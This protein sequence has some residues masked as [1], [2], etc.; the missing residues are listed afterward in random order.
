MDASGVNPIDRSFKVLVAVAVDVLSSHDLVRQYSL[1]SLKFITTLPPCHGVVSGSSLRVVVSV[2]C[3]K[4]KFVIIYLFTLLTT[5]TGPSTCDT[6]QTRNYFLHSINYSLTNH[7][8]LC[9]LARD[10]KR[11]QIHEAK[12]EAEA[13][14]LRPRSRPRPSLTGQVRGQS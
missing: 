3:Y 9:P 11:G 14:H 10:V 7:N 2:A 8:S 12:A 5:H 4:P 1:Q 6:R 13:R